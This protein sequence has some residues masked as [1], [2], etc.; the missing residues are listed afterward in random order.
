MSILYSERHDDSW[1]GRVQQALDMMEGSVGRV[2]NPE[3][4]VVNVY[5]NGC[6]RV[7][8]GRIDTPPLGWQLGAWGE[9]DFC[10]E[11]AR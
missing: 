7:A 10:P 3:D 2:L 6:G 4:Y 11:C 5:C 1:S 8:P 9:D